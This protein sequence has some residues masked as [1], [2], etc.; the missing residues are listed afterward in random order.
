MGE[1]CLVTEGFWVSHTCVFSWKADILDPVGKVARRRG[2][3]ADESGVRRIGE[4]KEIEAPNLA[5]SSLPSKGTGQTG[6]T[7]TE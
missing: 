1:W 6:T 2:G 7:K 3:A 5:K 4:A